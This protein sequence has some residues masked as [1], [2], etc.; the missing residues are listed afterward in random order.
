MK[1][2]H[3]PFGPSRAPRSSSSVSAG[4]RV[5]RSGTTKDRKKRLTA[6]W[7]YC[8]KR[9]QPINRG[10]SI[11]EIGY[12]FSWMKRGLRWTSTCISGESPTAL[13]L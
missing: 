5:G 9:D 11:C 12:R 1:G 4:R 2:I 10:F 8:C 13:K 6:V 3:R 7:P